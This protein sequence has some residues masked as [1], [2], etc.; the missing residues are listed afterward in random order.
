MVTEIRKELSIWNINS[1]GEYFLQIIGKYKADY[2]K[3]CK[4][5]CKERDRFFKELSMIRYLKV[6]PSKANYF[7]CNVNSKFTATELTGILL[8]KYGIF[9]KD[10]TGKIGFENK[11]YVRIA[12]RDYYDNNFIVKKLKELE[13]F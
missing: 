3:A 8:N 2:S 10:C 12:V 7:L 11:N 13:N 5:I 1:F 4:Q 6:I 9:I